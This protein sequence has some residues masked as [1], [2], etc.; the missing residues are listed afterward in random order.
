MNHRRRELEV[1][2]FKEEKEFTTKNTKGTK[3]ENK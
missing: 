1:I 3:E 2:G